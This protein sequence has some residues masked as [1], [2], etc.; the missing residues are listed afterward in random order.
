MVTTLDHR[1][2]ALKFVLPVHGI[3]LDFFGVARILSEA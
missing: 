1:S 3:I 2:S